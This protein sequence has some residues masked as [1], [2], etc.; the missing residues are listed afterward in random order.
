M[1]VSDKGMEKK[2][3]IIIDLMKKDRSPT[4]TT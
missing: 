1:N 2:A 4:I 3:D